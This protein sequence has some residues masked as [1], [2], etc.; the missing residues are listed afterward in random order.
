MVMVRV[1]IEIWKYQHITLLLGVSS[2]PRFRELKDRIIPPCLCQEELVNL[3]ENS[4]YGGDRV[5]LCQRQARK[6]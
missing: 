5:P 6:E 4:I 1:T 3:P 2:C